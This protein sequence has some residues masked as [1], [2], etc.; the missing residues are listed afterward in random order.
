MVKLQD[1][2]KEYNEEDEHSALRM[3]P[4]DA[5]QEA[6]ETMLMRRLY[7]PLVEGKPKYALGEWVRVSRT[8]GIFEKG[9]HPSWTFQIYR[10]I[11]INHAKPIMYQVADFYGKKMFGSYYETELQKVADANYW[12]VSEVLE[13]KTVKGQVYQK[14][15]MIGYE[16]PA[17]V[18]K[19][20]VQALNEPGSG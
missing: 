5:H 2:V 4:E 19:T 14:A 13:E 3:T 16:K 17:W 18:L 20:D 8:K 12:P 11:G 10:V 15:K 7:P 1:F 9:F 6:N